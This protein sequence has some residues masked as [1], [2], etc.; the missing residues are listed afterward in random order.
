[1]P[2]PTSRSLFKTTRHISNSTCYA[3]SAGTQQN[4]RKASVPK[5]KEGIGSSPKKYGTAASVHKEFQVTHNTLHQFSCL[6]PS[7][8]ELTWH[9]FREPSEN[10]PIHSPSAL[11]WENPRALRI[12]SS[13]LQA[14]SPKHFLSVPWAAAH[15]HHRFGAEQLLLFNMLPHPLLTMIDE[16][17]RPQPQLGTV[18]PCGIHDAEVVLPVPQQHVFLHL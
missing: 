11:V 8:C 15:T 2:S 9:L 12:L 14:A 16:C 7:L 3:F 13:V 5:A 4:H 17:S 1:M 6:F 10:L 18:F